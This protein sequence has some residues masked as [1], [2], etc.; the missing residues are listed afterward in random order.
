MTSTEEI[1]RLAEIELVSIKFKQ[2]GDSVFGL[3]KDVRETNFEGD[4]QSYMWTV[5]KIWFG[6]TM[7]AW[8]AVITM[9]CFMLRMRSPKNYRFWPRHAVLHV[10]E[11]GYI[12]SNVRKWRDTPAP[13]EPWFPIGFP[14]AVIIVVIVINRWYWY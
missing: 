10:K 8:F 14:L 11:L 13:N 1:K 7:A 6:G 3:W 2:T 9:K 5:M 12:D 4:C